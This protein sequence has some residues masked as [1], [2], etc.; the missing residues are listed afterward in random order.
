M[1]WDSK[2]KYKYRAEMLVGDI[3]PYIFKWIDNFQVK[4]QSG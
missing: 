2:N 3:Y 1:L 4:A